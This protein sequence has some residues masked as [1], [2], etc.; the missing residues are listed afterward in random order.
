M[1]C[2]CSV[3]SIVGRVLPLS[4]IVRKYQK[5]TVTPDLLVV[6]GR[7][8]PVEETESRKATWYVCPQRRAQFVIHTMPCL[9]FLCQRIVASC[10]PGAFHAKPD[11]YPLS[12]STLTSTSSTCLTPSLPHL[13]LPS[14]SLRLDVPSC[15][16]CSCLNVC[17]TVVPSFRHSVIPSYRHTGN[18]VYDLP[19]IL[20]LSLDLQTSPRRQTKPPPNATSHLIPTFSPYRH[21]EYL[22]QPR[23]RHI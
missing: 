8:S 17:H 14:I 15:L 18:I 19:R 4:C 23:R 16:R 12:T 22:T 6:V 13:T 5:L 1:P 9:D 20:H 2:V 21:L 11:L 7:A 10:P 3:W